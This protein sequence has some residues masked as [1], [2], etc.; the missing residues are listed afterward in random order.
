MNFNSFRTLARTVGQSVGVVASDNIWRT[1]YVQAQIE[2]GNFSSRLYRED[3]N[4]FGMRAPNS[5]GLY[6]GITSSDF[7]KYLSTTESLKD[8]ILR[9]RQYGISFHQSS[10]DY[11]EQTLNSGYVAGADLKSGNK[12]VLEYYKAWMKGTGNQLPFTM[13]WKPVLEYT[14]LFLTIIALL[15]NQS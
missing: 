6:I 3:N 13:P 11:I 4:M 5:R 7:A 2:T 14:A 9:Q 8:Y 10:S 12:E 1:V 15:K